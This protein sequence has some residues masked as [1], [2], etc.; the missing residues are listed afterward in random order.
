MKYTLAETKMKY[1]WRKTKMACR[2]G[3][4]PRNMAK[5]GESGGTSKKAPNSSP[6]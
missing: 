2:T 4:R 5:H 3:L 6:S 1:I